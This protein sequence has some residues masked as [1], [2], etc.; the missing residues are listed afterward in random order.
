MARTVIC[1][2]LDG[3]LAD[4]LEAH[5]RS[6]NFAFQKNNLPTK[7]YPEVIS[8]FG[9]PS[10]KIILGLF[11]KLSD[12]KLPEVAKDK[13]DFFISTT[14]RL[15]KPIEGVLES[16]KKLKE[17]YA[18]ALASNSTHKEILQILKE[19]KIPAKVFDIIIGKGDF[20]PKPSPDV[21]KKVEKK[22]GARV[23]FI[24][25]DTVYDLKAG[26]AAGVKTIAVLSGA[27]DIKT[28]GSEDPTMIIKSVA[29]LPEILEGE[30]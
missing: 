9:Q 4:T 30:M 1:F 16:L 17:R 20:E 6:F 22:S 28:L 19:A 12:R 3:T 21:I 11:P 8:K 5:F 7:S 18:I 10:E 15:T 23:E 2:D 13:I 24:V 14:F 27:G 26:K 25:G 29:V